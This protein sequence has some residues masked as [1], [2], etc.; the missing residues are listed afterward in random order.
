MKKSYSDLLKSPKWQKKRLEI[1]QRDKFTCQSCNDD[2]NTLHV[3]HLHYEKGL[4]PWEYENED[5]VTLCEKCHDAIS[6]IDKILNYGSVGIETITLVV[7]LINKLEY[8]SIER[9]YNEQEK[10]GK[11][12]EPTGGNSCYD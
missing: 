4:L 3:H 12:I 5:L 1:L 9:Y 8:E 2:I 10:K 6:S 11:I 7:K